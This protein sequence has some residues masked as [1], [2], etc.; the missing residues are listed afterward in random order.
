[1]LGVD[2]T[3]AKLMSVLGIDMPMMYVRLRSFPPPSLPSLSLF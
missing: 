3:Q 1:V 2:P